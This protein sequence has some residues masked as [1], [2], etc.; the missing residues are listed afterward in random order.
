MRTDLL[1]ARATRLIDRVRAEDLKK[2]PSVAPRAVSRDIAY[3]VLLDQFRGI[4]WTDRLK[5]ASPD[6]GVGAGSYNR[7]SFCVAEGTE[8]TNNRYS[9][10]CSE[11][12]TPRYCRDDADVVVRLVGRGAVY[13][14]A[15]KSQ[16]ASLAAEFPWVWGAEKLILEGNTS[17][18]R[19]RRARVQRETQSTGKLIS[20]TEVQMERTFVARRGADGFPLASWKLG[21]RIFFPAARTIPDLDAVPVL[22]LELLD[23]WQGESPRLASVDAAFLSLFKKLVVQAFRQLGSIFDDPSGYLDVSS[24]LPFGLRVCLPPGMKDT[25]PALHAALIS[26]FDEDGYSEALSDPSVVVLW[27]EVASLDTA[28]SEIKERENAIEREKKAAVEVSKAAVKPGDEFMFLDIEVREF[29]MGRS[30]LYF[31]ASISEARE[32]HEEEQE[33]TPEETL[34]DYGVDVVAMAALQDQEAVEKVLQKVADV[35]EGKFYNELYLVLRRALRVAIAG[36]VRPAPGLRLLVLVD[37]STGAQTVELVKGSG[38]AVISGF[39]T[40]STSIPTRGSVPSARPADLGKEFGGEFDPGG[41]TLSTRPNRLMV[42]KSLLNVRPEIEEWCTAANIDLVHPKSGLGSMASA[43][44]V[45]HA[46]MTSLSHNDKLS[47]GITFEALAQRL[48]ELCWVLNEIPP[49]QGPGSHRYVVGQYSGQK[50][51]EIA[52][53]RAWRDPLVAAAWDRGQAR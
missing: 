29:C 24:D 8:S 32:M 12:P 19:A 27:L 15:V 21:Y 3:E 25:E 47:P 5:G 48:K 13:A 20:G 7:E 30:G 35:P 53:F 14:Q 46:D 49:F 10:S 31:P 42:A 52:K 50:G 17:N 18:T 26:I 22:Q 1:D 45:W 4:D 51:A 34:E 9:Q 33:E 38:K 44:R 23:A 43:A 37:K 6:F 11:W 2:H 41:L 39:L 16:L 28:P 36:K 40:R